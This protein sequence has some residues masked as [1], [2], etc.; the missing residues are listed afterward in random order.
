MKDHI[1]KYKIC[2]VIDNVSDTQTSLEEARILLNLPFKEGSSILVTSRS[3]YILQDL[4]ITALMKV[5]ALTTNEAMALFIHHTGCGTSFL[6]KDQRSAVEM[7]VEQCNFKTEDRV[8]QEYHPLAL[9][10]LGT[11]VG[12]NPEKWCDIEIDFKRSE[13]ENIHHIFSILRSS[14][15]ALIPRYQ[16]MFLDLALSRSDYIDGISEYDMEWQM[17]CLYGENKQG[18]NCFISK[19]VSLILFTISMLN[20]FF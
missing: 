11:R 16:R 15:D 9:K 13:N 3:K 12:P 7:L 1:S 10:V 8:E 2:L 20:V 19:L 14:Y 4:N 18:K 5:P 6:S 17:R